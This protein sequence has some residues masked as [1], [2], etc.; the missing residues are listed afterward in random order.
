MKSLIKYAIVTLVATSVLGCSNNSTNPNVELESNQVQSET[1]KPL[2]SLIFQSGLPNGILDANSL[3]ESFKLQMKR[4]GFEI[5]DSEPEEFVTAK[6]VGGSKKITQQAE[7][8]YMID[9]CNHPDYFESDCNAVYLPPVSPPPIEGR[10]IS[11]GSYIN[12]LG[13]D[14]YE[15]GSYS[16]SDDNLDFIGVVGNSYAGAWYLGSKSQSGTNS[17]FAGVK[18]QYFMYNYGSSFNARQSGY[19][20]FELGDDLFQPTSEAYRFYSN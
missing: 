11:Y 17:N 16:A 2:K 13:A 3:S 20:E 4:K 15:F 12:D 8:Q 14:L 19:H 6:Y 9:P 1:K 7:I 10:T 18:T 5:P